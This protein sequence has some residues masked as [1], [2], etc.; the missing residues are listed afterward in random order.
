MNYLQLYK[1]IT[2]LPYCSYRF[3]KY[4]LKFLIVVKYINKEHYFNNSNNVFLHFLNKNFYIKKEKFFFELYKKYVLSVWSFKKEILKKVILRGKNFKIFY[5]ANSSII[6]F[7]LGFADLR[8]I[9]I[10][11]GVSL[12]VTNFLISIKGFNIS[13][14]SAFV[15]K[16]CKL[17]E[18]HFY[19]GKGFILKGKKIRLKTFKK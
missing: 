6:E 15:Y 11:E 14:V 16:L 17:K 2:F 12:K 19:K 10:P 13:V 5:A 7:K 8:S 9:S 4:Q 3:V 18:F 1:K